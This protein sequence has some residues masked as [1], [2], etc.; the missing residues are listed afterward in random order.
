M[1][2]EVLQLFFF[3]IQLEKVTGKEEIMTFTS[4]ISKAG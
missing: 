2:K 1:L 4:S 3:L